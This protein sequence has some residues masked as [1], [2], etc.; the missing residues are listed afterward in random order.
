MYCLHLSIFC[1]NMTDKLEAEK[2]KVYCNTE[3]HITCISKVAKAILTCK[4][5]TYVCYVP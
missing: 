1:Y 4:V 3:L 5:C 2:H